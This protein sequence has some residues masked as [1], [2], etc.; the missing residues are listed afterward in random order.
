[1]SILLP[2]PNAQK[3]CR[4]LELIECGYKSLPEGMLGLQKLQ[5]LRCIGDLEDW[6]V[7]S[8][9]GSLTCL[10]SN[11]ADCGRFGGLPQ[12]LKL[13]IEPQLDLQAEFRV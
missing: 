9:L 7:L 10:A 13:V 8:G 5:S 1:M 4:H 11:V 6:S 3:H 2:L 12:L